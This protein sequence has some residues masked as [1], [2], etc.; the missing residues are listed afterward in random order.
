MCRLV[1]HPKSNLVNICGHLKLDLV[2]SNHFVTIFLVK[3]YIYPSDLSHPTSFLC[4]SQSNLFIIWQHPLSTCPLVSAYTTYVQNK[5]KKQIPR[6]TRAYGN[7][8]SCLVCAFFGLWWEKQG[9]M[10]QN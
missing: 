9:K 6:A 5:M 2:I 4:M 10:G 1:G 3:F 8:A 7:V